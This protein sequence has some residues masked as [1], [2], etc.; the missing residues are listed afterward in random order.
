MEHIGAGLFYHGFV[1]N[2]IHRIGLFSF[3]EASSNFDA[4]YQFDHNQIDEIE[5]GRISESMG[6]VCRPVGPAR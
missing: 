5:N 3:A 2:W 6:T 4:C 1:R